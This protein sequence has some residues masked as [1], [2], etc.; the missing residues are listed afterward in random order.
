MKI[1]S[2]LSLNFHNSNNNNN[3]FQYAKA[4]DN[5]PVMML[6]YGG[7]FKKRSNYEDPPNYL[8]NRRIIVVVANYRLGVLGFLT[9]GDSV[10]SGNMGLKDQVM[11]MRWIKKNIRAFGG[12][13]DNVTLY[14]HSSGGMSVHMHTLSPSSVGKL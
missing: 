11:A 12:D 3:S 1:K 5:I 7:I 2:D 14:G 8:M 10:I 6:I 9:T 4:G 13:P